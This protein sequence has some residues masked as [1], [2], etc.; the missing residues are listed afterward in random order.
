MPTLIK[1][2][3][4]V[5]TVIVSPQIRW[6]SSSRMSEADKAAVDAYTKEIENTVRR[7]A[8]SVRDLQAQLD[9]KTV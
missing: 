9:G 2:T 5:G 1:I 7:L 4:P 8:E 3:Q 6:P